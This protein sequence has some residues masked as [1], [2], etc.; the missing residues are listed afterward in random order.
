MDNPGTKTGLSFVLN[1]ASVRIVPEPGERLSAA[2]RER[3][4]AREV[5]IG[6]NA[7]DCGACSVLVDGAVVCAC[8]M[9]AHQAEGS[10]VDTVRGLADDPIAKALT[11]SFQDHQAAQCGIC[12]P[13]MMV[14][15]V[16]LLRE[17]PQPDAAQVP[18]YRVSQ[19]H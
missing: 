6:C 18:L 12:T 3:L 17:V 14:S 2:L 16:A 10:R 15:A 7:G 19:D 1:G 13:A 4:Q 8:L 9:A 5:K 11:E